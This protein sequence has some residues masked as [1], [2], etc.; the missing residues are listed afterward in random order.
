MTDDI[1]EKPAD[2]TENALALVPDGK[3]GL[4]LK[5]VKAKVKPWRIGVTQDGMDVWAPVSGPD[6]TKVVH[7]LDDVQVCSV[8]RVTVHKWHAIV[9]FQGRVYHEGC[10]DRAVAEARAIKKRREQAGTPEILMLPE[11]GGDGETDLP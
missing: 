11:E 9:D 10:Y 6:A 8:C 7:L 2:R 5:K 4:V 1:V 3:G